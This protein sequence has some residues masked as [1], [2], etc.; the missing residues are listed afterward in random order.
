M[1]EKKFKNIW[2]ICIFVLLILFTAYLLYI[3]ENNN[4]N[5]DTLQNEKISIVTNYNNF[6]TVNSCVYRYLTYLQNNDSSSLLKVLDDDY[7]NSKNINVSNVYDFLTRYDGN[8]NFNS[9]KMYEEQVSN[10]VTKYY[11]YGYVERD[12]MDSFPEQ[13]D[14]YFIVKLDSK[15]QTFTIQPYDGD[16]FK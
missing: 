15:N 5:V 7:I 12:I 9:R 3:R 11:V 10:N 1:D 8:V 14:E 6:Y 16:I 4:T 13:I 2:L